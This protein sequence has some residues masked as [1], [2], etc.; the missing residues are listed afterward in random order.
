MLEHELRELQVEWPETPDIAGAIGPRVA[1]PPR[2]RRRWVPEWPA[3][4]I[5]VAATA[6][7]IA[8]VMV[9]PPARAAV[10]DFLGF[11]SVRIERR[12]P[13]PSSFGQRVSF[14]DPVTLEQARRR[15]GFAVGV[16]AELGD[17]DAVYLYEHPTAG[18]RVD[19]VYRPRPG[20][21]ASG[22]TGVGLLITEFEAVATPLIEKAVG[23]GAKVEQFAIDGDP[24]IFISGRPHGFAY[25]TPDGNGQFETQRLAGNTLLVDRSDGVLLRLEGEMSRDEAAR[26]AES[27]G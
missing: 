24:A 3:W 19:M 16:P 4:Q 18:S 21:E 1:A 5:A 22:T 17:P 27:V 9:I 26:I 20:L 14:G 6:L 25:T 2:A 10:L 13:L 15:A 8:V 11:S 12:E 7:V 23:S